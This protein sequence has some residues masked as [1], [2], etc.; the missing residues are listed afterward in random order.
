MSITLESTREILHAL[1]GVLIWPVLIGLLLMVAGLLVAIGAT[2]REAWVRRTRPDQSTR[3]SLARLDIEARHETAGAI[4]QG[5]EQVL[6]D[7]ERQRWRR[8]DRLR[9]MVRLGPALGLMGT[10][11]PMATALQGLARGDMPALAGDL[12][13]AFAATVVGLGVS[14]LAYLLAAVREPWVR[15]DSQRLAS[16]ADVLMSRVQ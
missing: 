9:M 8:L 2:A 12:V 7:D 11:I 5:L 1:A 13:T 16:H 6:Q 14:V 4:R 15:R 3:K 10:L